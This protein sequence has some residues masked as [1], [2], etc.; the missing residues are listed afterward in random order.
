MRLEVATH[1]YIMWKMT[2]VQQQTKRKEQNKKIL[3]FDMKIII[4]GANSFDLFPFSLKKWF[5]HSEKTLSKLWNK[6][7]SAS[8]TKKKKKK[9]K[10][11]S[12]DSLF[13]GVWLYTKYI[14]FHLTAV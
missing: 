2:I 7:M 10:R 9:K 14:L 12:T 4:N 3:N 11:K 1:T 13:I 5:V 6:V 8:I